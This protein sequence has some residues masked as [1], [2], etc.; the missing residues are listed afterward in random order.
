MPIDAGGAACPPSSSCS[1]CSSSG[2]RS[3]PLTRSSAAVL[4]ISPGWR[5]PSM[6]AG[7]SIAARAS[8]VPCAPS[9]P[10]PRSSSTAPSSPAL[11]TVGVGCWGA[12]R[13][14]TTRFRTRSHLSRCRGHRLADRVER[15]SRR[16]GTRTAESCACCD[17]S[18]GAY[19]PEVVSIAAALGYHTVLWAPTAATAAQAPPPAATSRTRAA[20]AMGPSCCSTAGQR[21]PSMRSGASSTAIAP[22]GTASST[23]ASSS[24]SSHP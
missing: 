1:W 16:A 14:P 6:T 15:A 24:S 5:S 22:V 17:A 10:L 9:A 2:S 20:A 8:C 7:A 13:W 3:R 18:Y 21:P 23:S 4:A 11:R 12:S 19:D